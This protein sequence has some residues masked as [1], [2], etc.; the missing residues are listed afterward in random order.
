MAR[1]LRRLT[2]PVSDRVTGSIDSAV[3]R[4]VRIAM[5]DHEAELDRRLEEQSRELRRLLDDALHSV[6]YLLDRGKQGSR[7]V[8]PG[9]LQT[10][11]RQVREVTGVERLDGFVRQTYKALFELELRGIGRIAGSTPNILGKL[12]TTP[13]LA[14][15]PG[16]VL[17]IGTLYGIFAG[18]LM[19]QFARLG[20]ARH[21]T[22]LDPLVGVQLQPGTKM[23]ADRSGSPVLPDVVRTNLHLAGV[24]D[25]DYR[26]IQGYSTDPDTR[27]AA[28]DRRYGVI[29]VDGDHSEEG[30]Y[31]DVCWAAE[32]CE[33][34]AIVVLDDYGDRNWEGVK[35][36]YERAAAQ[37][38]PFALLGS[39]STSAYLRY[40]A[41]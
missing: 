21:L 5:F 12:V 22:V 33:P 15:P 19:R 13:L 25:D 10:L 39:V 6:N 24:G 7:L 34:A 37:G 38:L 31:E 11:Q 28:A 18:G 26:L 36:G 30:V 1:A 29:I 9:Q 23:G 35:A 32:I 14:P 27:A 2:K 3:E 4:R 20:D 8:K 41:T 16:P 17:E 40:G